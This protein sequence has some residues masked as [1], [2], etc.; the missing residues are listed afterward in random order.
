MTSQRNLSFPLHL[1]LHEWSRRTLQ[2]MHRSC[3][4]VN[5][6]IRLTGAGQHASNG[7]V[8]RAAHVKLKATSNTKQTKPQ[9]RPKNPQHALCTTSVTNLSTLETRDGR[10]VRFALF[11]SCFLPHFVHLIHPFQEHQ[12]TSALDRFTFGLLHVQS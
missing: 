12:H 2:E 6:Q 11:V 1:F 9:Q 3:F 10:H 7:Q 5:L 8:E 4:W